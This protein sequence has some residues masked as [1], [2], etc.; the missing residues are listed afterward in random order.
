MKKLL[1]VFLFL[2]LF[3]SKGI[4]QNIAASLNMYP[5]MVENFSRETRINYTGATL[6]IHHPFRKLNLSSGITFRSI[7]WGS[8][9]SIEESIYFPLLDKEGSTINLR[10]AISL[11]YPLFYNKQLL[12]FGASTG[13]EVRFKK[14]HRLGF[15]SG[16]RFNS[17]PGYRE[18]SSKSNFF[19]G[20]LG[21]KIY[22]N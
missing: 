19:E 17:L 3:A 10:S 14:F 2:T 4:S 22:R 21:I 8:Q 6:E 11:A 7:N 1:P 9:L 13:I 16:A 18:L 15:Y 12:G 5:G 20:E